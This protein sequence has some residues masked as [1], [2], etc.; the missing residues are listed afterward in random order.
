[1][2]EFL[3]PEKKPKKSRSRRILRKE[4]SA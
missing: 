4:F 2:A 1:M 3:A